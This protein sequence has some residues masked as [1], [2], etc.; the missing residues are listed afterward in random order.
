[1]REQIITQLKAK[2]QTLGVKNLSKSRIDAIADKL[3]PKITEESQIDGK[4]DELNELFP[5]ADIAKQDDKVRTLEAKAKATTTTNNAGNE[6]TEDDPI[7]QLVQTVQQLNEKVSSFEKEKQQ[8]KL[9]Q[10]LAAKLQEKKIPA[11]FLKGRTVESEDQL[12]AVIS[13][14]EADFTAVKQELVNQGFSQTSA[15]VGGGTT[16]KTD[17]VEADILAHFGKDK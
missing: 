1:M 9:S 6:N 2:L 17:N 8:S 7:K 16:L 11:A 13:E 5:F 14:V 10:T 15:P 12:D 4:L 3:A